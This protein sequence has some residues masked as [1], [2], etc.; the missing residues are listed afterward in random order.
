VWSR[1]AAV[2]G[3]GPE[4]TLLMSG[5]KGMGKGRM[6]R[7]L[8]AHTIREGN[9]PVVVSSVRGNGTPEGL[10]WLAKNM[11]VALRKTA[12][13]YGKDDFRSSLLV[14]VTREQLTLGDLPV[15]LQGLYE[16]DGEV[17]APHMLARIFELEIRKLE[18]DLR[19]QG[20]IGSQAQ[21]VV[22][23]DDLQEVPAEF[24]EQL[25][26]GS[27]PVLTQWGIGSS[28]P[29]IPFIASYLLDGVAKDRIDGY[30]RAGEHVAV[31]ELGPFS[32]VGS[33]D[34]R[35]YE[36][37]LLNPFLLNRPD[38]PARAGDVFAF[39]PGVIVDGQ[40]S[41]D[42]VGLDSQVVMLRRLLEGPLTKLSDGMLY[43]WANSMHAGQLMT[44]SDEYAYLIDLGMTP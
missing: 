43:H 17:L 12:D 13:T 29:A 41:P 2:V 16:L 44:A 37:I 33:A 34:L 7:E 9:L 32:T 20:L 22:F 21:A 19:G 24:V 18:S 3:K 26:S 6:I 40:L 23:I 11:G 4:R 31:V 39:A 35:S 14:K 5:E 30:S 28:S 27:T 36:Q 8:L 15:P 25:L 42:K 38:K 1:Y 10:P